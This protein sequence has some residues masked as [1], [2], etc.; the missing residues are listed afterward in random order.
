MELP[1]HALGKDLKQYRD[2]H[3][4]VKH[5]DGPARNYECV[6]CGERAAHWA[7]QWKTN[8]GSMEP[9]SF[10]PM[11]I[12]CH[13]EYDKEIR[14]R[15]RTAKK[16]TPERKEKVK[17]TWKNKDPELLEQHAARMSERMKERWKDP[18]YRSLKLAQMEKTWHDPEYRQARSDRAWEQWHGN[19]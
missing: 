15:K 10:E 4:R 8:N 13:I 17:N 16:W 5:E 3:W 11:R 12:G 2:A 1:P 19:N 18:A 9:E 6:G 14:T 7:W